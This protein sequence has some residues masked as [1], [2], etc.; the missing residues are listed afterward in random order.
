MERELLTISQA[1]KQLGCSSKSIQRYLLRGELHWHADRKP[2]RGVRGIV[3]AEAAS[4][5]FGT[6]RD[7]VTRHSKTPAVAKVERFLEGI[8]KG[9]GTRKNCSARDI[10][11]I[12]LSA[13]I[14]GADIDFLAYCIQK[15]VEGDE[16]FVHELIGAKQTSTGDPLR[17]YAA[18][19]L[20]KYRGKVSSGRT[21]TATFGDLWRGLA[22][23]WSRANP[24]VE[25]VIFYNS[26]EN[27]AM[28]GL[29]PRWIYQAPAGLLPELGGK[30]SVVRVAWI[31]NSA[32]VC[33]AARK[34]SQVLN[35]SLSAKDKKQEATAA[36]VAIRYSATDTDNQRIRIGAILRSSAKDLA[37]E[38]RAR[39]NI[40][41][42]LYDKFALS[43]SE[44]RALLRAIK[45]MSQDVLLKKTSPLN[46]NSDYA[47][48][49]TIEGPKIPTTTVAK[50]F[51]V[52]RQTVAKWKEARKQACVARGR[53]RT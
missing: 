1:A 48:S 10:L 51:G 46:D 27:S 49:S 15:L 7:G 4:A 6:G 31:E 12:Y 42:A 21:S 24:D 52:S 28:L 9:M 14:S 36:Y 41:K 5:Q 8:S 39:N 50:V 38:R 18:R 37:D 32:I 13:A 45:R 19:K 11:A 2:A 47:S 43:R 26:G 29:A 22:I 34:I 30:V 23:A 25:P 53:D 35:A 44:G 33:S 3:L 17:R 20:A 40:L 16:V